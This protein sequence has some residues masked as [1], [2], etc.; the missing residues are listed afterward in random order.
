MHLLE[1]VKTSLTK[2][3]IIDIT[4]EFIDD[5]FINFIDGNIKSNPGK[6]SI[7]FNIHDSVSNH[8]ISLYSIDNGFTMNDDMAIFLNENQYFGVKVSTS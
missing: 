4:P 6:A 2:Q 5:D 8:K 7:R 3:I 1:T